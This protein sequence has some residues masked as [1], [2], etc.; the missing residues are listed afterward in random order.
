MRYSRQELFAPIGRAG[1]ARIGAARVLVAGCGGLGSNAAALLARAGVGLLRLVDRDVVELSNLQRQTLFEEADARDGVPKASAAA[2]RIEA[3]NAE[4][5]VEAVV[6]DVGPDNVLALLDGID[7]V[8]DGFDSF[9]A[10][11]VLNDACVQRGVPWVHGACVG[12][13]AMA[14]LVVPGRTPCL[15]CLHRELPQAGAA[16]TCD[17]AGIIGPA[18]VLGASLQASIALRFLVEGGP[19]P[20]EAALL[21]ADAWELTLDRIPLPPR[22]PARCPCCG[23]GRYEYLE[24]TVRG[25]TSLC[26][27][28]AVQVRPLSSRR[29]DLAVVAERLRG[30][31]T[32]HVNDLLL[33]L[34]A[35]PYELTL[36][37][38]GRVIVKGTSD[39]ALA[40]SLVSR[41]IGV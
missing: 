13:T 18:A 3:I 29:P 39:E 20:G 15:R 30:L 26:G 11:Y 7:L 34:R 41:W 8:L 1:Q 16:E 35:P 5:K 9:E 37:D 12:S 19:P 32:V 17:T 38:D 36:F 2:R 6:A 28:D 23:E 33:R 4:V 40:R 22:D 24:A 27:R 21:C 31:G 25:V 10:R 14:R